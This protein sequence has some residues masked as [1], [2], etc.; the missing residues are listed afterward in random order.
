MQ[1]RFPKNV[2]HACLQWL[3]ARDLVCAVSVCKAWQLERG[4]EERLWEALY[5]RTFRRPDTSEEPGDPWKRRFCARSRTDANWKAGRAQIRTWFETSASDEMFRFVGSCPEAGHCIV[6]VV[7]RFGSFLS[8]GGLVRT[9]EAP[10]ST[11]SVQQPDKRTVTLATPGNDRPEQKQQ[12]QQQ[13]PSNYD[14]KVV[15]VARRR[16]G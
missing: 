16:P 13:H 1:S 12:Q 10:P 11:S 4:V 2:R 5:V 3:D 15:V 8:V 6:V 9:L 14:V 7:L